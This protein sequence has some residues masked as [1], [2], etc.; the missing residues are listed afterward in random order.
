MALGKDR[1]RS[2]LNFACILSVK[3]IVTSNLYEETGQR[4]KVVPQKNVRICSNLLHIPFALETA[5]GG[6]GGLLAL[7]SVGK[8]SGCACIHSIYLSLVSK[9]TYGLAIHSFCG[10]VLQIHCK[11]EAVMSLY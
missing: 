9:G 11:I 1:T 10:R 3:C 4:D 8:R 2:G 6:E 7:G 5:G